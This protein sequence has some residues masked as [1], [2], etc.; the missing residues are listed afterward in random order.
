M[1]NTLEQLKNRLAQAKETYNQGVETMKQGTALIHTVED[2]VFKAMDG[3]Q[4]KV[5]QLEA[6]HDQKMSDLK[7]KHEH[8]LNEKND[9]IKEQQDKL[10]SWRSK[11]VQEAAELVEQRALVVTHEQ[12][13]KQ[14]KKTCES[15]QAALEEAQEKARLYDAMMAVGNGNKRHRTAAPAASSAASGTSTLETLPATPAH[16]RA[17]T[18][19][20]SLGRYE[21]NGSL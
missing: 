16:Q 2:E 5:G 11:P 6:K 9:K 8:E 10:M 3:L 13:A 12:A 17:V 20:L 14:A 18:S 7:A 15:L 19:M 4:R 1:V 21:S